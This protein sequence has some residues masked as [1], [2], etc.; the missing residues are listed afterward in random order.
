MYIVDS[1]EEA[2]TKLRDLAVESGA[3]D[4]IQIIQAREFDKMVL[5]GLPGTLER[6]Q[7]GEFPPPPPPPKILSE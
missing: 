7:Q 5:Y 1:L 3:A 6:V 4:D 2:Y